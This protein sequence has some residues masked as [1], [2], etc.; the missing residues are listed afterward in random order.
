[1][2]YQR[3]FRFSKRGLAPGRKTFLFCLLSL[4][5][6]L[7]TTPLSF[8]SGGWAAT[9]GGHN[10]DWA[11]S[12][13]ETSD[14]G[15]IVAGGTHS[16]DKGDADIWVLKLR[17]DGSVEWQKSYGGTGYDSA[18]SIHE[19]SDG[20]Y[21]VTSE[22][23]S[24]GAGDDDLCVLKLRL[25]GSVEWQK[26]Y[27]D[28]S[29]DSAFSTHETR[30]GGYIVAGETESFGAGK[31]DAWVLKLRPDGSVEWQK[32]YGGFSDDMAHSILE[33]RDGGCI[34]AGGTESFGAGEYDFWVIKLR[35]D[36]SVE[37]Q[38][39]YGGISDDSASSIQET[40]DGGYIVSGGTMS[41]GAGKCDLWV[42]KLRPDGSVEW[43]KA[44]G[45]ISDDSAFST[46]E[47]RDGGYIVAGGTESFGAGRYDFW[48]LKLRPDGSVEWQKSYGGGDYEWAY[49]IQETCNGGYIVAGGTG[50]FGVM[51]EKFLR[52]MI[53]DLWILKLNPDGSIHLS[54]DFIRETNVSEKDSNA[55]VEAT[56]MSPR[57]SEARIQD[58]LMTIGT[59]EVQANLLCP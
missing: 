35:P 18:H 40:R 23:N 26:T 47:T 55:I 7:S 46:H 58:S 2:S 36:G 21:I 44:Y 9:Y 15:Y 16:L 11:E 3:W 41:F 30:D 37:W 5:F 1:M 13:H 17:P 52:F 42:L 39:T 4:T 24:F 43:Q 49:S 10:H 57:D 29:D 53:F 28:I 34:V 19:T 54:C 45:D 22:T 25:D 59:T 6:L 8:A 31:T 51:A 32:T 38:K 14:G 27:G 56:S 48:V 33:T 12:I 50:S 20:G